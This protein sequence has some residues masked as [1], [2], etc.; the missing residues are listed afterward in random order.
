MADDDLD[1]IAN[2]LAGLVQ[3]RRFETA[4]PSADFMP[5]SVVAGG[6]PWGWGGA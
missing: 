4:C 5:S 2:E 6:A 3:E 1:T